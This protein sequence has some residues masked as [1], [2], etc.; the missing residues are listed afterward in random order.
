V[1]RTR[2]ARVWWQAA[3]ARRGRWFAVVSVALKVTGQAAELMVVVASSGSVRSHCRCER[4]GV[5][6]QARSGAKCGVRA[7]ARDREQGRL[8]EEGRKG[9]GKGKKKE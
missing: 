9:G 5:G 6:D 3:L 1:D 2:W 4:R 8:A 7:E